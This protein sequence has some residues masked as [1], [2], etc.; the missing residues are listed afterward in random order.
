[1]ARD[2]LRSFIDE[3]RI[4]YAREIIEISDTL[5]GDWELA[6]CTTGLQKKL[7]I[8][9]IQ[10]KDVAGTDFTV[11]HNVC[12]SLAR[13]ARVAGYSVDELESRLANAYDE[14]IPPQ[15]VATGPVRDV[16]LQGDALD[17]R[18][19]PAIRYTE[20][21]THPYISAACLVAHDT[22]SAAINISY[23]RLMISDANT[24][25]VYM[26]PGGDLD[27]IFRYNQRNGKH[28]PVAA[29]I[30]AHPLWSLGSLAAGPLSLDEYS[31]IG[32]LLGYPLPVVAGLHDSNLYV[33]AQA[34]IALEGHLCFADEI[35]E[36]P[37]GEAFGYVSPVQN[38]PVFRVRSMTHRQDAM[39]QD[40]V[41]GQLEHMTMT[42]I[43]IKVH[44]QK[45]LTAR[46]PGILQIHLPA[47]MTVYVKISQ[48][49]ATA[50]VHDMLRVM[51][52]QQR[53]IKNAV[54]FD[55][56]VKLDDS[57]QTQRAIAMHVQ[58]DRDLVVVTDQPGNGLDPSENNGKTTKWGID[59]TDSA[60]ANGRSKISR[61][62][63]SVVQNL[64]VDAILKRA[65]SAVGNE[66]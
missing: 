60:A 20:S 39:F 18:I 42:S 53:F 12:A 16:V 66:P 33:P 17:V 65:L 52:T 36:G 44:L 22:R 59:A 50:K 4:N 6:A 21:Q 31:V 14:L 2:D 43:A 9:L 64:D 58:A 56:D 57:K 34:E 47:P 13:I 11:V 5:N 25:A 38:S 24:L 3:L 46:F 54:V 41:P 48:G 30:G 7:R 35:A 63:D 27:K 28:T 15:A 32:G 26:T 10:Y 1:M 45:S 23:H 55:A 49:I 61:L 19:L 8:P 62:P 40:I 29:F 51:L 37:Y